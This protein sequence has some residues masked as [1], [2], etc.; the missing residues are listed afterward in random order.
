MLDDVVEF[1]RCPHCGTGL[2]RA[3]AQLRCR[4]QHS[5]DVAR[6]G[7]VSLLSGAAHAGGDSATMVEARARFLEA[8]HYAPIAAAVA[9][10]CELAVGRTGGPIVDLGAGTGY[11]L[12]QA[13]EGLDEP[14]G[15]ALDAS[16]HALRRAARAHRRIGA[17]GCD[18][19]GGLPLRSGVVTVALSVF[20]PRNP[21]EI[22]RVLGPEGTFVVV[23]PTGRHLSVLVSS[24]GLLTVDERKQERIDAT[25]SPMFHLTR[26][27]TR[28][29]SMALTHQDVETVVAMGPSARH[30]DLADLPQRIG[31]LPEPLTV[32][33][34][35][36]LSIYKPR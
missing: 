29:F 25:L 30:V 8:G 36:T 1:L 4:N 15:L 9:D 26:E 23:T 20:S 10:E 24:L 27:R 16:K 17:V 12:A 7:Y 14:V 2:A 21:A 32:P 31:A 22:R 13:L 35:V 28:E 11:Y 18:I 3:D 33:A 6:Q 5:Y 34:S 19:W